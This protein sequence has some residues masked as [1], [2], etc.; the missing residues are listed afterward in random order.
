V[1]PLLPVIEVL[2]SDVDFLREL[3]K[4]TS[5]VLEREGVGEG[6]KGF[7]TKKMLW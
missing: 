6:W 2:F 1:L 7:M 5:P 3:V 4:W